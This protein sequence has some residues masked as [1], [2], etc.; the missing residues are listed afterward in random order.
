MARIREGGVREVIL[1]TDPTVEGE[2]TALYIARLLKPLGIA[3]SRPAAGVP[4]GGELGSVDRV[5]LSQALQ[6]RREL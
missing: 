4:V 1:A 2:T 6:L 5:T 3:V